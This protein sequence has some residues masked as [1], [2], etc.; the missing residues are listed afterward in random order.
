MPGMTI[1]YL[2]MIDPVRQREED[3]DGLLDISPDILGFM[4]LYPILPDVC[5]DIPGMAI[6]LRSSDCERENPGDS[7]KSDC[8][9]RCF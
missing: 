6:D 9:R 3:C 5:A 1:D 8:T 2:Y 4:L 7:Y